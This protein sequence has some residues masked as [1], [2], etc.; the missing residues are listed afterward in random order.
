MTTAPVY[1]APTTFAAPMMY[2]APPGAVPVYGAPGVVPGATY[3]AP[4]P[5]PTMM[6]PTYAAPVPT[7]TQPV[8]TAPAEPVGTGGDPVNTS[9][10]A[11]ETAVST[12]TFPPARRSTALQTIM[13]SVTQVNVPVESVADPSKATMSHWA[14]QF[15]A[16]SVEGEPQYLAGVGSEVQG[17]PQVRVAGGGDTLGWGS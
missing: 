7:G 9:T 1:S 17:A 15:Q 6:A 8:G 14:A 5:V 11:V 12:Q 16:V 2:G 4:Q 10:T 13:G 3:A